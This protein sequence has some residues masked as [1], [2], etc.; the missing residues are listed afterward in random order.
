MVAVV[1]LL[2]VYFWILV[3]RGMQD[4]IPKLALQG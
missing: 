3:L 1:A 2:V 4:V